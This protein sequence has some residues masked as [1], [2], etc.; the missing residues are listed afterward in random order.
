MD[1]H[2]KNNN[3][4]N[5]QLNETPSKPVEAPSQKIALNDKSCNAFCTQAG[6]SAEAID[7]IWQDAQGNK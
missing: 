6:L 4:N 3:R 1:K 5:G 7:W 2:C